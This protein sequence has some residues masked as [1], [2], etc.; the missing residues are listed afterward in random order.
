MK[1]VVIL[2]VVIVG[3]FLMNIFCGSVHISI[4]DVMNVLCGNDADTAVSFIV[5]QHRLP[6]ACTALLVGAALAVAGLLL[7][8]TF[9]NP[10]AGPSVLGISGGASLGVA[11]VML[12]ASLFGLT[13]MPFSVV[14]SAFAGAILVTALLLFLS[15]LLN[16]NTVLLIVGLLLGYLIS[17]VITILN[18]T[19]TAQGLRNYVIWGMGDF[20]GVTVSQ[21]PTFSTILL[22][23]IAGSLLLIKPLNILQLGDDYARN[24]GVNL[25]ALRNT[26]LLLVGGITA[27]TTA[28]CGPVAFLGLAVPHVARMLSVTENFRRLLP[29]TIL[30]GGAISLLCNL[31]CTIP[32]GTVLPLNAVTPI[33]GIPVIVYVVLKRR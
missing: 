32:S 17:A 2:T 3:L 9:H 7:Q 8:T 28:Y 5:L 29:L 11:I 21:L 22:L 14:L 33:I 23:L 13:V 1:K 16:N 25:R 31:L 27:I 10:L 30:C 12:G 19:A 6:Q 4:T 26:M 20:S 24:L 15:S 18:V